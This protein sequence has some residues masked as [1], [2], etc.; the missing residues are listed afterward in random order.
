[1]IRDDWSHPD[2]FARFLSNPN[3]ALTEAGYRRSSFVGGVVDPGL[4]CHKPR[5]H[6]GRL[7]PNSGLTEAGY[8][9][10]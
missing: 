3:S 6:R 8:N 9:E 7:H 4:T 1:M 10:A 2:R 5:P